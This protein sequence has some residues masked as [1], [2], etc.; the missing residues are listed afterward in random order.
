MSADT[1]PSAAE[2]L[3]KFRATGD[4]GEVLQLLK[5]LQ[6]KELLQLDTPDSASR[7]VRKNPG[8]SLMSAAIYRTAIQSLLELVENA[9]GAGAK[10]FSLWVEPVAGQLMLMFCDDGHGVQSN[11][12]ERV[13]DDGCTNGQLAQEKGLE[14]GL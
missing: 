11:S 14:K 5:Q 7:P 9:V 3:A 8:A 13:I 1:A 2:L 4:D 12:I 6:Q 10:R